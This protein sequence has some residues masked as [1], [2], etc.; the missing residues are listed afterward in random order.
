MRTNPSVSIV[1]IACALLGVS[2]CATRG[3][4]A[5]PRIV[6]VENGLLPGFISQDTQQMRLADRMQHYK[7]PAISIAV[8]E[9]GRV[10]W[11]RAYGLRDVESGLVANTDTLFQAASISKPV[12]A[13]AALRLT[14]MNRLALDEDVNKKLASWKVP[15]NTFTETQ[16][17]TLRR[18]LTHRAGLSTS[19][20]DGYKSGEPVPTVQQ[21]LDGVKPANSAA[22][23]VILVPQSEPRYS[24]GGFTVMQQMVADV[25]GQDFPA[26]MD[27]LVLRR[28]GM[29]RST[30]MQPP[31]GAL[32]TN[33]AAG[34]NDGKT[35]SG[36]HHNHPELAAA[37]LWTT[38]TDLAE[39]AIELANAAAGKS[40]R[41]SSTPSTPNVLSREMAQQMLTSQAG[42]QWGLGI[43]L[44]GKAGQERFGH[45][46]SNAGF[47]CT[48]VAYKDGS[49]GAVIMTNGDGGGSLANEVMRAIAVEYQWPGYL[50]PR[51][52][53]A[54]V[55]AAALQKLAGYYEGANNLTI[56]V[57]AHNG[58]LYARTNGPWETFLSGSESRFYL[59]QDDVQVDFVKEGVGNVAAL[60]IREDGRAPIVAKRVSGNAGAG[61]FPQEAFF[62]RGT[63][64]NWS[65]QVRMQPAADG[66]DGRYAA[67]I[68]LKPGTYEFKFG[69]QDY[70]AIDFG[71][72]PDSSAA[73]IGEPLALVP[74][75]QN[76]AISVAKEARY[77]FTLVTTNS[78][79]PV[80]TI[81]MEKP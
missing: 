22:V 17:V 29:R 3:T 78:R 21:V 73:K 62:L 67:T 72:L 8:I 74:V 49:K 7:T 65:T 48:L 50:P 18:I 34:H 20:F 76:I 77:T 42:D 60:E 27:E 43:V 38:P 40:S 75:G 55:P 32:S 35:I 81:T 59:D 23:R 15:E 9:N 24:G 28:I 14:E 47:R 36:K 68:V 26:A 39:F 53:L 69:S 10:A 16:K 80:M 13:M 66:A 64:N 1:V 2:A 57:R 79:E 30:Y 25:T 41:A 52:T 12:A 70:K 44:Q 46:G 37:G 4:E 61:V 31:V 51:R 58:R 54:Q 6:R 45:S 63:M 11:S 19:G 71:L 56:S 33:L 5:D